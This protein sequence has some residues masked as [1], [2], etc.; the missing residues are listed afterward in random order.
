MPELIQ[1]HRRYVIGGIAT[2]IVVIYLIRLFMLQ[3]MS[4]DF[5]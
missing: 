1:D 4:D 3:I 2:F 5:K